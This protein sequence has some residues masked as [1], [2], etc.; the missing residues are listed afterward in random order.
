MYIRVKG[1]KHGRQT[2]AERSF[3]GKKGAE[4][5]KEM[6]S[7]PSP[8]PERAIYGFVLYLA[9][10]L[11]LGLYVVWAY[12]P[13]PWLHAAGLTYWPQKYW[14]LAAPV[15]ISIAVLFILVFYVGLN[16]TVTAPLDSVHTVTDEF[17]KER[18]QRD[19]PPSAIPPLEDNHLS[20]VNRRL[21]REGSD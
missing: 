17:A 14:A 21:Y 10:F 1:Y 12:V 20:I 3:P 7:S 16:F 9:S 18:R 15:Y 2:V 13:E 11:G 19:L 8:S 5:H 6:P 4:K